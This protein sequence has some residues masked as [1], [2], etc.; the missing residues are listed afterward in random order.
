[1]IS[2]K[3]PETPVSIFAV[4]SQLAHEHDA[5][6]LAQGF[7]DFP[8]SGKLIDLVHHYMKKGLNQYAPMPGVPQLRK[9]IAEKV[10]NSYGVRYH[11]EKE[12][13]ITAGATQ[14]IFTAVTALV[15]PGDEVIIFEPAYD[16]YVPSVSLNGGI[17]KFS[18]LKAPGY[19]IDHAEV[20][21]LISP[22]TRM[23]IINT[24]HN[25]TGTVLHG[26][27]MRF[28]EEVCAKNDIILL[29]DEVYE[30]LIYDGLLHESACRYPGLASRSLVIGSFGKTFHAT[31]WKVGFVLAPEAI[32]KEFRKSHQFVVFA[33][34]TPV[35]HAI[36]EFLADPRNYL[37]LHTFYQGKR[38]L[39]ADRIKDS[40]L[41]IVPAH[42]TYFQCVDFSAVSDEPDFDFARR[43]TREYGVASIPLSPFY[44]DGYDNSTL[45]FCFAK[46]EETILKAAEIL[47]KI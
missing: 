11:P 37:S 22:A 45:R 21:R 43:M 47:C 24:P 31:G 4:M 17:P 13:T 15:R 8:I 35:Q 7:P 6:N 19:G 28:L 27:D 32:M 18:R 14:A 5:I 38:D 1:M 26:N 39:F 33:V 16:S 12:I 40:R 44:H 36:A 10:E 9:A 29:S 2:S 34:N 25:P 41:R 30:H 3:L 20:L 42:G 46:K 23:I